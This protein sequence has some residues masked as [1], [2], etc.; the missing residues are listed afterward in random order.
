LQPTP[1]IAASGGGAPR[2]Y[3]G[4]R[5]VIHTRETFDLHL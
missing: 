4:N 1:H 3:L 2:F 5:Q